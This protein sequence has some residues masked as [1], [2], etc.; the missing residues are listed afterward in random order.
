MTT[1]PIHAGKPS[2]RL[3]RPS[4]LR[5]RPTGSAFAT[6]VALSS[7]PQRG[8]LPI[9]LDTGRAF[10][11]AAQ[12]PGK[13]RRLIRP[14]ES[15][16]TPRCDD[17]LSSGHNRRVIRRTTRPT[18][19]IRHPEPVK[20][21]LLDRP[22]D[23]PHQVVLRQPVRQRRRHQQQLTTI[24][25]NEVQ[26]HTGSVLNPPD[27]TNIPTASRHC[28]G[29]V[30]QGR[31]D[32]SDRPRRLCQTSGRGADSPS[33]GISGRRDLDALEARRLSENHP[34]E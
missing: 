32:G 26:S 18:Q 28:D 10:M 9:G 3:K 5:P 25:T 34:F 23:G 8:Q 29:A 2:E 7:P 27:S 4:P 19:P 16:T 22:Q 17:R 13:H 12:Q 15:P 31:D 6:T 21:H 1:R 20:I 11:T 33:V 24:T 14:L 30:L